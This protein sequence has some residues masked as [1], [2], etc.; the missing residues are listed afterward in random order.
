MYIFVSFC[1]KIE[2]FCSKLVTI[3]KKVLYLQQNLTIF[4]R[5]SQL[6]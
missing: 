4:L 5:D 3:I 2:Y 1:L 6:Q